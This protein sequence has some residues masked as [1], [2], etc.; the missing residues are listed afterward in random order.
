MS[1]NNDQKPL[2]Q[3]AYETFQQTVYGSQHCDMISWDQLLPERQQAWSEVV[4]EVYSQI[5]MEQAAKAVDTSKPR[6]QIG[7]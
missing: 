1:N 7:Q 6:G 4:N 5:K 2:M 3:R